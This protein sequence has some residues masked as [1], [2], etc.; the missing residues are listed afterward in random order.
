MFDHIETTQKMFAHTLNASLQ[1]INVDKES[2][3]YTACSFSVNDKKVIFRASKITPTKTG[4]F[5]TIWKRGDS[6]DTE[7]LQITDDFDCII[8]SSTTDLEHGWFVFPKRLLIEKEI[9]TTSH[10]TGKRGI[11]VYPVWDTPQSK[12]ALATQRWQTAFFLHVKNGNYL[13]INALALFDEFG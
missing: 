10:K 5:V 8:I 7:P 6:G 12:L 9:V 13:N 11:R 2:R 4:Q 3:D 1:L